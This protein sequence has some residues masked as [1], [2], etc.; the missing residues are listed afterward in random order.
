MKMIT[1]IPLLF[2]DER[3]LAVDKPSGLPSHSLIENDENSVA[4][5]LQK[6]RAPQP[7]FLLHRL[8]TGT[9][10]VLLFAKDGATYK[11]MREQFKL[12]KIKKFYRARALLTAQNKKIFQSISFPYE[13]R[14]PLAHHPKSKKRM[15]A[16]PIDLAL[17]KKISI[18]GKP[19]SALT[20][21]HHAEV[22][23]HE[24]KL[25]V[26]F[27]IEIVTGVMHQ[28]RAHLK[29][30]GFPLLGDPIY[31]DSVIENQI[32]ETRLAL[33]SQK[34]LFKMADFAYE[35]ESTKSI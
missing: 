14:N 29:H 31:R 2:E 24:K 34:I 27:N 32:L 13:I 3:I 22:F 15:I 11:E 16:L 4:A 1:D 8:D 5:I 23:E 19:L 10:G 26:L 35:I 28:I 30:I 12:K 20:R 17:A 33:H 18:R 9:S 25:T 21:I 7:L 6:A